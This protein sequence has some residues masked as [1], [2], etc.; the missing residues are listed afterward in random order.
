MDDTRSLFSNEREALLFLTRLNGIHQSLKFT[1][2][3]EVDGVHVLPFLDV[4]VLRRGNN[5]QTTVYR[6]PTFT[7]L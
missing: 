7:G 6:E 2:E 3:K 1:M 5:F 4:Q